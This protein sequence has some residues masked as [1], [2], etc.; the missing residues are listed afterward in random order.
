MTYYYIIIIL[1][2]PCHHRRHHRGFLLVC[3]ELLCGPTQP[4]DTTCRNVTINTGYAYESI[5]I[6][7]SAESNH[8]REATALPTLPLRLGLSVRDL[9]FC[10]T[11]Q[12]CLL[13]VQQQGIKARLHVTKLDSSFVFDIFSLARLRNKFHSNCR[14]GPV[15]SN[16]AT[17]SVNCW[18]Y[19]ILWLVVL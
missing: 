16:F 9:L 17:C 10:I 4:W 2:F 8:I 19:S 14:T 3:S 1:K 18:T 12:K 11:A 5:R 7:P 6:G 13:L 15:Q